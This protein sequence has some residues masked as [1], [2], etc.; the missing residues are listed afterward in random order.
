MN[1]SESGSTSAG[2][3][4]ITSFVEREAQL[5]ARREQLSALEISHHIW[6]NLQGG[7]QDAK[8]AAEI[9]AALLDKTKSVR[10]EGRAAFGLFPYGQ[11]A[12]Q[13]SSP[14]DGT[15]DLSFDSAT[16][17]RL[18]PGLTWNQAM[19]VVDSGLS[20]GANIG[21][22]LRSPQA[23]DWTAWDQYILDQGLG[24]PPNL[25]WP[26]LEVPNFLNTTNADYMEAG[27][28]GMP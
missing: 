18:W 10:R 23:L 16:P 12:Q 17:S 15:S 21:N 14:Q 28:H 8:K 20:V 26:E 11:A 9:L 2:P 1:I 25:I 6:E 22:M 19:G 27:A 7:S 24:Y 13:N 5:D 4:Y 3:E